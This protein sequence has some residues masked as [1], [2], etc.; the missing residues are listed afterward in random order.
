MKKISPYLHKIYKDDIADANDA[1]SP[2]QMSTLCDVIGPM[3]RRIFFSLHV[4]RAA[5]LNIYIG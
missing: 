3:T 1:I 2:Q 4:K 5:L